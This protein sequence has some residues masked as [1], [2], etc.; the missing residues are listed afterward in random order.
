MK[1]PGTNIAVSPNFSSIL[2]T[3]VTGLIG[4]EIFRELLRSMP[5]TRIRALIRPTP[6]AC[7]T[8]RLDQR[9]YRSG[10]GELARSNAT[11]VAGDITLPNWGMS[12]DDAI[13][14]A[15]DVEVIIHCAADTSFAAHDNTSKTN[16]S[17]VRNLIDFAKGCRK[18]PL[19]VYLGTATNVGDVSNCVVKE[20]DGCQP[21]HDHHNEY[22]RSKAVAE[23]MLR[24]SGL[25]LLTLRPTIVLGAGI[26]D[27]T[28][29]RQILW[30]LPLT[31]VFESLPFDPQ[32]R[33]DIVD[34]DF[35]AKATVRLLKLN[36]ARNHDCYNLSAGLWHYTSVGDILTFAD[37]HYERDLPLV[38]KP[39]AEWT[40]TDRE[41]YVA[42]KIQKRVY[43][44]LKPYLPFINMDV[45]FDN[46]RLRDDLGTQ[47]PTPKPVCDYLG[48][49]LDLIGTKAAL[50][51]A[52]LP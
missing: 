24:N 36:Q 43:R 41:I 37:Q 39:L 28:F 17:G 1:A 42:T 30:C 20:E 6:A 32:A 5:Q 7:E 23:T 16:V 18:K 27:K 8:T 14:V 22:T 10:D 19:I 50:Q 34:V 4:G 11:A 52:A 47:F 44:S 51:E 33:L 29:A 48:S 21:E 12:A 25:P 49:L 35:V 38:A 13:D 46:Q 3:G 2:I 31:R 15:S 9:L 40:R 45:V 26:K